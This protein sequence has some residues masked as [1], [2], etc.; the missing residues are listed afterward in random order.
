MTDKKIALELEVNIKKG[1]MT[2]GELNSELDEIRS[3][4]IQ[5]QQMLY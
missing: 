1:D 4:N 3:S 5:E 2:L